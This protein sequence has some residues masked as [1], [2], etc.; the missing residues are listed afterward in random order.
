[1]AEFAILS[2]MG[3]VY[4]DAHASM[5]ARLGHHRNSR[6]SGVRKVD[7]LGELVILQGVE[8]DLDEHGCPSVLLIKLTTRPG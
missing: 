4:K 6:G 2:Q 8:L 5:R 7:F 3:E 1:M